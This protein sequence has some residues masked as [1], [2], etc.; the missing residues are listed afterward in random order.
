MVLYKPLKAFGLLNWSL[1]GFTMVD[2]MGV[3]I[4]GHALGR[5]ID[6]AGGRIREQN[7][8]M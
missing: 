6:G 3:G 7:T 8:D 2:D 5:T 1:A 4:G